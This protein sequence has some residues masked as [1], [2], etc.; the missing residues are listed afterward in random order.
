MA[1]IENDV[2]PSAVAV[3]AEARHAGVVGAMI[4]GRRRIVFH[5]PAIHP[6]AVGKYRRFHRRSLLGRFVELVKMRGACAV[7]VRMVPAIEAVAAGYATAA[8]NLGFVVPCTPA[9][10]VITPPTARIRCSG[11]AEDDF[12]G[13]RA[14]IENLMVPEIVV[15]IAALLVTGIK[16]VVAITRVGVLVIIR[17]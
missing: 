3:G 12:M 1:V 9:S 6:D 14:V 11:R 10:L 16:R 17:P 8:V 13:V 2:D 5:R 7:H 4:S 15:P